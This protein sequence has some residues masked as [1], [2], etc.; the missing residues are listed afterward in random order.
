MM[1]DAVFKYNKFY[2]ILSAILVAFLYYSSHFA[3]VSLDVVNLPFS[4]PIL[5]KISQQ[6]LS[7]FGEDYLIL[8]EVS[9]KLSLVLFGI[10]LLVQI[11]VTVTNFKQYGFQN[12]KSWKDYSAFVAFSGIALWIL[13]KG[14][15]GIMIPENP[16][17]IFDNTVYAGGIWMGAFWPFIFYPLGLFM[18]SVTAN[19]AILP[20]VKKPE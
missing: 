1:L 5:D 6:I 19:V 3:E 20:K 4:L 11:A 17:G 12:I 8:V 2:T 13:I 16:D 14:I 18:A 9:Y 15:F 10:F 7:K